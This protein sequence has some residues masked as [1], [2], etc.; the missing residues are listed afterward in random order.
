M[1]GLIVSFG[2]FVNEGDNLGFSVN[3]VLEDGSPLILYLSPYTI[4]KLNLKD[5]VNIDKNKRY[6]LL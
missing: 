4:S 5:L 6:L 3:I 1:K 2:D